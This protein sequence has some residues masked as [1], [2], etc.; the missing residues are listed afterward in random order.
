M[1]A[2]V[3]GS[4]VGWGRG[5]RFGVGV[6]CV[7]A[8]VGAVSAPAGAY[9]TA[10]AQIF[11]IAGTP[12]SFCSAPP[13]GDG[14]AATGAT[15]ANPFGVAVDGQGNVLIADQGD[16]T[17]RLLAGLQAGPTG[18]QGAQGSQGAQGAQGS[19]GPQGPQGPA[20]KLVLVAFQA[21]ARHG[22]VSVSYALT[23]DAAL[24][25]S[26]TPPHGKPII[27]AHAPGH[28]GIGTL[29][30]NRRLHRRTAP[31]GR[32][33]LNLTATSAKQSATSRLTIKI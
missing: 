9:V 26:V 30:W 1:R 31:H 16:Q 14:G 8:A 21:R 12:L 5:S 10:P 15:L 4:L 7:A 6:L 13:C 33:Q 24:T 18:P 2:V 27:V 11:T 3:F 32:Y 20:A 23:A 28:P 17:I 22:R 25:L 19:Q 29:T